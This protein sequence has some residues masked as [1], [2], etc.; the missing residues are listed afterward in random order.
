MT[1]HNLVRLTGEN[2]TIADIGRIV[3]NGQAKVIVGNSTLSEIKRS[4]EF[5]NKNLKKEIIY[6][7]NTGFGP[8]ASYILSPDQLEELQ[9]N[10]IRSHAVGMG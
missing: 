10:L 5:L 3:T 1:D 7:I 6:G 8:M 9:L 4:H 2:L